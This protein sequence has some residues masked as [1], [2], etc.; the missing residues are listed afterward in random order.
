[1]CCAYFVSIYLT[2]SIHQSNTIIV[3]LLF[4]HLAVSIIDG[5]INKIFANG[6]YY[7]IS[8]FDIVQP[9]QPVYKTVYI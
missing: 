1:M 4:S 9:V 6:F 5:S 3:L 2:I 8:I 7:M